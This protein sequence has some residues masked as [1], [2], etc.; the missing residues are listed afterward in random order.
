MSNY[1]VVVSHFAG[2]PQHTVISEAEVLKSGY[3]PAIAMD[4]ELIIPTMLECGTPAAPL[5]DSEKVFAAFQ[6][7]QDDYNRLLQQKALVDEQLKGNASK[8]L[9]NEDDLKAAAQKIQGLQAELQ[10][11]RN[12]IDTLTIENKKLHDMLESQTAP[13]KK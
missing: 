10:T 7:L 9:A 2:H 6:K 8:N 1:Q 12:Q 4:R 3:S 5:P 11:H 13:A